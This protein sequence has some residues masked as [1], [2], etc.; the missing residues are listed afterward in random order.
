MSL[1]VTKTINIFLADVRFLKKLQIFL[2][3]LGIMHA[4]PPLP[5]SPLISSYQ[6][7]NIWPKISVAYF[8]K[9]F[10]S[11]FTVAGWRTYPFNLPLFAPAYIP[12]RVIRGPH[13]EAW[14]RPEPEITSRN[15]AGVRH[16]FLKTDL[17]LKAKSTEGVKI[18]ATAE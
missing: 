6:Q 3:Q 7:Q 14:T 16:L 8:T 2:M 15:P 11:I 17:G 5:K 10:Q 4:A 12:H 13:F 18:C 1:N 9:W